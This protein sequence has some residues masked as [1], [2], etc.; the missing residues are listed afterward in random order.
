MNQTK[1]RAALRRGLFFF[2][3]GY[4]HAPFKCP[5]QKHRQA[6]RK[7]PPIRHTCHKLRRLIIAPTAAGFAVRLALLWSPL[8]GL[9]ALGPVR[10]VL[11]Q[12]LT[13]LYASVITELL[14]GFSVTVE[15][16]GALMTFAPQQADTGPILFEVDAQCTGYFVF[17][18]YLGAVLAF[19]AT[20]A[21]RALAVVAGGAFLFVLNVVRIMSLYPVKLHWPEYF[22]E[23][24]LVV[25]QSAVVLL[26]GL[27]W[28]AWA[29]TRPPTNTQPG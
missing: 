21:S 12:P 4:T 16:A 13:V 19:P 15:R 23:V 9:A 11:E 3:P 2:P 20:W 10:R 17:W 22:D 28:Y 26:V 5:G 6:T 1:G 18:F 29:S 8:T 24:H 27:F 7:G 25:W 14:G